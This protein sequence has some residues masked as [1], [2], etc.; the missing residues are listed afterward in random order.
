MM[1]RFGFKKRKLERQIEGDF[2]KGMEMAV[3]KTYFQKS[4]EHRVTH[5]S[6]GRSTRVDTM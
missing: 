1:S 2:A 3:V 4:G 5:E 6:G